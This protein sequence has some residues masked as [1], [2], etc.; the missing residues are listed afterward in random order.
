MI[1][2]GNFYY[3]MMAADVVS[4]MADFMYWAVNTFGEHWIVEGPQQSALKLDFLDP[5]VL[6]AAVKA[7]SAAVLKDA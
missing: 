3:G 5:V 1:R 6:L 7:K 4:W 2:I